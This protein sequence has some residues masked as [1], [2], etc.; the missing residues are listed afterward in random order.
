[1]S[2]P[3]TNRLGTV[4]YVEDNPR[5]LHIFNQNYDQYGKRNNEWPD[6]WSLNFGAK[7]LETFETYEEAAADCRERL[8][9]VK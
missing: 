2:Q 4:E 1:M 9:E 7:T 5:R 6:A 8:A 3:I